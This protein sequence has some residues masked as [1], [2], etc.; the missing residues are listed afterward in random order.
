M[1]KFEKYLEEAESKSPS[2][3]FHG[4]LVQGRYEYHGMGDQKVTFTSLH[5]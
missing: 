1:S 2:G 4:G 5:K 3:D